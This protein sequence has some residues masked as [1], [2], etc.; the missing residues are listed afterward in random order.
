MM[1]DS[2]RPEGAP[3]FFGGNGGNRKKAMITMDA[4]A[5]TASDR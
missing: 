1:T 4:S 3:A 5:T 2:G